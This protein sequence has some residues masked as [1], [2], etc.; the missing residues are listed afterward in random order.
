[1][2]TRR[3]LM[4]STAALAA[5]IGGIACSFSAPGLTK[6]VEV[7]WGAQNAAGFRG[8]VRLQPEVQ[9]SQA[10]AEFS[11]DDENPLGPRRG[12]Y[13]LRLAFLPQMLSNEDLGAWVG[14]NEVDLVTVVP[15]EARG[16]GEEGVLLPLDQFIGADGPAF[17][18]SFYPAL[19]QQYR[20]GELYA[21]PIDALPVM[22][23]YIPAYFREE[24]KPPDNNWN[25]DDLIE[26]AQKLTK[27]RSDGTVSRWGLI[28]HFPGIWWALWQNEAEAVDS[29][30]LQCRLQEPFAIEALQ[31]FHAMLHT[32]RVSPPVYKDLWKIIGQSQG[33]GPA[34][35]F[36]HH[37]T[38][39]EE[40]GYRL[41]ALPHGKTHAV[42]TWS[43]LGVG[44][45][46]RS[47]HPEAAYT[48]LKG[49]LGLM[50][51]YV[52]VP[53]QKQAGARLGELRPD[54]NAAEVEAIQHSLQY[55]R[56]FMPDIG[57]ALYAMHSI[58]EMLVHGDDVGTAVDR[59]CS[60]VREYNRT[61]GRVSD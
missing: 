34:M 17:T 43:S 44:I 49:L 56:E 28:P 9:I 25:W 61:K 14:S 26:S 3:T 27:Q 42:P 41:A 58:L 29:K 8:P 30:T 20:R 10:I 6:R 33:Q 50:Q 23:Q 2:L 48:A 12:N 32:Y 16:L 47:K 7:T 53:A 22:I 1:M 31:F 35:V 51:Q 11:E 4:G 59:G 52:Y 13:D 15:S 24:I 5:G 40:R 54:L 45:A 36:N 60:L 37:Q 18:Q 21:L 46:S 38:G 39:D 55:S 19:L 57:V